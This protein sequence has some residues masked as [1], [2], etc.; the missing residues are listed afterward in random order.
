[1]TLFYA[2]SHATDTLNG[3]RSKHTRN[4]YETTFCLSH[5][6]YLIATM[7]LFWQVYGAVLMLIRITLIECD[8][9]IITYTNMSCEQD[10]E[11]VN[12][13]TAV[14]DGA[15]SADLILHKELK[16]IFIDVKFYV[17]TADSASYSL[18][19]KSST[20]VCDFLANPG[21]NLFFSVMLEHMRRDK[22]NRI[23][24]RCPVR[25]VNLT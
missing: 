5:S 3:S 13:T 10:L 4:S 7:T 2:Y 12:L 21:S 9:R 23:A 19:V 17:K 18:F 24:R 16:S 8:Q 15:I 1:M 22:R 14:K 6:F 20:D 11:I 25:V